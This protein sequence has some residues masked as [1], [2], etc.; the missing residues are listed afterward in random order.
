MITYAASLGRE[1]SLMN[2]T[3]PAAVIASWLA[4]YGAP[5]VARAEDVDP[6]DLDLAYLYDGG[7]I[8][9]FYLPLAFTTSLDLWVPP[10]E[11]P[12]GFSVDEG[13]APSRQ[14]DEVPGWTVGAGATLMS[15]GIVLSDD[16][17]RWFHLKGMGEALAT[18]GTLTALAKVT[19][20]RHRPDFVLDGP[21]PP[22]AR[23]S[24][25]SGHAST[26]LAATTYFALY[27]RTH[28]FD[29]WREPGTLPWWEAATYTGLAAL[30]VYVP[31]TR[32]RD[33][34]HHATDALVGALVGAGTATAFFLWQEHRYGEAASPLATPRL[35]A[36]RRPLILPGFGG[37]GAS[38]AVHF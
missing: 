1:S 24:F 21:N 23:R 36:A 32:V 7:V 2:R 33:H 4:H 8:P 20:G 26:S 18:T 35:V 34:R 10:R 30:A 27:L 38:L 31:Y 22:D 17:A 19:F 15:L 37:A 13:G 16:D 3:L 29:R 6:T 11:S 5:G 14:A 9:F 28:G 12:L 25:F